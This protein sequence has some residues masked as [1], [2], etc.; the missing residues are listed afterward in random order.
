MSAGSF[1]CS[2]L[3]EVQLRADAIW[4]DAAYN[5]DYI[6]KVEALT[7]VRKEQSVRLAP[8]EQPKDNT[9]KLIWAQ[10]CEETTSACGAECTVGGEEIET[11]CETHTLDICRTIGFTVDEKDMRNNFL[12][13]EDLIAR[14]FLK[15]MKAL[16]EYLAGQMV[17]NLDAFKG[18]NQYTGGKGTVAGFTTTIAP[19]YWNASLFS[20][21]HLV[22]QKNKFMDSYVLSGTNLF[23]AWWNAQMNGA[24]AD[25][26]GAKNMF[27]AFRIYFDV[28]NIDTQLDPLKATFLIDKNAV[29]FVSKAYYPWAAG[30]QEAM[31]YGG[32]GGE[33]GVKYQIESKN[34]PGVFYDVTYKIT[35][36]GDEIK[37]NF[38][39]NLKAGIFRNPVGC[40]LNNTGILELLCA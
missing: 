27:D 24:N 34:L 23:E 26:K 20:Y 32:A 36:S 38:S 33:V 11:K 5:K 25:G 17:V 28:F 14:A 2:V 30:S 16:D 12:G 10:D 22:A 15:K 8:L 40:N 1:T 3:A 29:A 13:V 7:A 6:A 9:I 39:L 37:H 4:A 35:C 31:K 21:L 19:A 18:V